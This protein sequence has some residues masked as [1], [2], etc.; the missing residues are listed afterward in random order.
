LATDGA[1]ESTVGFR[2]DFFDASRAT[3][4]QFQ[5]ISGIPSPG[6]EAQSLA[7]LSPPDVLSE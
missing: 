1:P 5:V 2:T 4:G 6:R 7:L 3:F